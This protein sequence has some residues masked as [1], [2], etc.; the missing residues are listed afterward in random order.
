[1]A[2]EQLA[3]IMREAAQSAADEQSRP[4]VACPEDGEPLTAGP[5]GVL[6]CTFCGW[7]PE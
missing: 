2:W 4:P 5:G 3:Q 1:V 7:R 6:F